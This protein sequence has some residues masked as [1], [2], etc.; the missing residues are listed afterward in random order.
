MQ[1]LGYLD[2]FALVTQFH[3]DLFPQYLAFMANNEEKVK[4]YYHLLLNWEDKRFE[5][6][7]KRLAVLEGKK[8]SR[9]RKQK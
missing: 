2:C 1:E 6:Y 9:K 5:K 4:K 8:K 7:R 3:Q